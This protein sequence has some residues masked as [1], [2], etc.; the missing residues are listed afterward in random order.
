[1]SNPSTVSRFD[2]IYNSTK[3]PV[4]A[5]ITAKCGSIEDIGDIF[6]ETYMELYRVLLKR[7]TDYITNDK[8]FVIKLAKQKLARH[9]RLFSQLQ[10][11]VSMKTKENEEL[12]ISETEA[13]NFLVEDFTVNKIILESARQYIRAKPEIIQKVFFLY[14]NS[15]LTISETAQLLSISGSSVK[16][17]LYR[18]IKEMRE[19]L[20]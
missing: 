1:M 3:K 20:S 17:H 11:F 8:A 12:D 14:Y 15:G 9:Y 16:N 13:D 4:L 19:R 18:T 7:G 6:Q 10:N 5:F 2:E